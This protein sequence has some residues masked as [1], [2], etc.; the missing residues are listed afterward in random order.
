MKD[1]AT[2]HLLSI[3]IEARELQ[4][5]VAFID[6]W[7]RLFRVNDSLEAYRKVGL[8][9]QLIDSSAQEVLVSDQTQVDSV[10]HWRAQLYKGLNSGPTKNWLEFLSCIDAHTINY[11]RMQAS[12]VHL[13]N[14]DNQIEPQE[15]LKARN[16]LDEAILEI[17]ESGLS[18][19]T[20]IAVIRRLRSIMAAIDDYSICG[21][22]AVF[23]QFKA[24]IFDLA[25]NTEVSE[26][27]IGKKLSEAIAVLANLVTSA[28]GLQQLASPA[29]KLLGIGK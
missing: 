22:E 3:L 13:T 15:L 28:T 10:N 18:E 21:N 29:L 20:K 14:S 4:V 7:K 5:N 16:M 27:G 26:K 23:D 9:Y 19:P 6:G 11:L 1:S 17:K 8:L 24:T 2:N 25:A 12:L